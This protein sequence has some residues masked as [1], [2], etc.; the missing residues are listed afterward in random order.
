LKQALAI[1]ADKLENGTGNATFL[2]RGMYRPMYGCTTTFLQGPSPPDR[3]E[4]LE[5]ALALK[6]NTTIAF[7]DTYRWHQFLDLERSVEER[8]LAQV[9]GSALFDIGPLA[10]ARTDLHAKDC[11]HF[12]S[13]PGSRAGIYKWWI[14][15]L[16]DYVAEM[17]RPGRSPGALNVSHGRKRPDLPG[18]TAWRAALFQEATAVDVDAAAAAAA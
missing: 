6:E 18:F 1:V 12:S 8:L 4:A 16:L 17:R 10:T 11:L 5:A 15:M 14:P 7:R 2:F 9:R 13:L 3:I